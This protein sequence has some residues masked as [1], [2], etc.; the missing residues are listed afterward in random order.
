MS[1]LVLLAPATAHWKVKEIA[2]GR[3]GAVDLL[4]VE[5]ASWGNGATSVLLR[6]LIGYGEIDPRLLSGA[7]EVS[8][9]FRL[10]VKDGKKDDE[11]KRVKK[12]VE[13]GFQA[14]RVYGGVEAP[15][16]ELW[17][18]RCGLLHAQQGRAEAPSGG[19]EKA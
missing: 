8:L 9:K 12:G 10:V 6:F 13:R 1:D 11:K 15:V 2:K 3:G 7:G 5:A 4:R 16:G 17:I 19:G 14:F 18:G